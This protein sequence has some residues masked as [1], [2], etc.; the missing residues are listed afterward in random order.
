MISLTEVQCYLKSKKQPNL[1]N[2]NSVIF[3]KEIYFSS[4]QRL[5]DLLN[6]QIK[7]N[8]QKFIS[9]QE[10]PNK[11]LCILRPKNVNLLKRILYR[12][13]SN[14]ILKVDTFN[15]TISQRVL[16]I[17]ILYYLQLMLVFVNQDYLVCYFFNPVLKLNLKLQTEK[18]RRL[19]LICHLFGE[20]HLELQ[21]KS[22]Q[23]DQII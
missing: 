20:F 19:I 6:L 5:N 15:V 22:D 1:C 10:K 14:A 18:N 2:G 9:M 13:Q 21:S 7:L 8:F 3:K 4:I 12:Q 17:P 23:A 11:F 16:I